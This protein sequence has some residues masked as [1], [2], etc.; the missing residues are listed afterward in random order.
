LLLTYEPNL[1]LTVPIV[2][3]EI[4]AKDIGNP[5]MQL[6]ELFQPCQRSVK[7][8]YLLISEN[9]VSLW[10]RMPRTLKTVIAKLIYACA[11]CSTCRKGPR[12]VLVLGGC[13]RALSSI[14][15]SW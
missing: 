8:G 11:N 5:K 3:E 12:Q 7:K 1:K 10:A 6:A 15:G 9:F 2:T 4:A 14:W 13:Y